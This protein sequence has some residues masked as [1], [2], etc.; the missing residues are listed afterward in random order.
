MI[1]CLFLGYGRKQTKLIK[2]LE[3]NGCKVLNLKR[4]ILIRDLKKN[5]IYISFGY[6][7]IISN[8]VL[9]AAKRPIINL[10]LSYLPFNRG[11]HP[12]YW[13][14][15]ENTQPGVSIHEID[16]GVDTGPILY[17]KKINFNYKINRSLTFKSSYRILFKEI[18]N[19]FKKNLK[20]IIKHS[21]KTKKQGKNYTFHKKNELPKNFKNWSKKIFYY[22]KSIAN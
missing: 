11:A 1:R 7:K 17:Q 9:K 18:E 15:M 5:D 20:K 19:L 8:K 12:N 3:K 10:H 21:Y 22:K 4:K 13:S 14:F 16:S 2:L 6:R